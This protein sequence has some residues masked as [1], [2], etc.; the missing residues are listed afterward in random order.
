MVVTDP[1]GVPVRGLTADH[2]TLLVDGEEVPIDYFSE[3]LGGRTVRP[4]EGTEV[5]A[6]PG[7]RE[8]VPEADG[9]AIVAEDE[10]T[11]AAKPRG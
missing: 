10:V 9:E 4:L 11:A 1:D 5:G 6:V 3:V 2:F 8:V 7:L